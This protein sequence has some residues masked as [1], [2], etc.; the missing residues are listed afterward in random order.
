M[1]AVTGS[2]LCTADIFSGWPLL[3]AWLMTACFPMLLSQKSLKQTE[4][5]QCTLWMSPAQHARLGHSAWLNQSKMNTVPLLAAILRKFIALPPICN[6]YKQT[7]RHYSHFMENKQT[8]LL[9]KNISFHNFSCELVMCGYLWI[10]ICG[11]LT[12]LTDNNVC[13]I[14]S[15]TVR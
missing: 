10:N 12:D 14:G 13:V 1:A 11:Y 15:L 6:F 3:E 9:Q 4:T 7:T 8:W 2:V 5:T